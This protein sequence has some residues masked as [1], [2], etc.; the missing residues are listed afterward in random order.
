MF[1][2]LN[3][4]VE[5]KKVLAPH[6][7]LLIDAALKISANTQFSL[8]LREITMLFLEQIADNYSRYLIRKNAVNV[9]DKIIETGFVIA[10]ESEADY[11]GEQETPHSLAL[12]MI[13][14]FASEVPNQIVYPIV[15]KYVDRFGTSA[16]DLE[17]K[18]AIKILGYISDSTCLDMIKE[19]I[20]KITVFIVGKLQDASFVVREATA[21]TV[22]K[23]SEH[24]V[25]DFL[26][27][28]QEVMPSLLKVL[29]ELTIQNDLTIQKSLFALHEFTNNLQDDV[30]QYLP[31]VVPLLLSYI[32]NMQYSRDVRYW[33]LTAMGSVVSS[34]QKRIVPYLEQVLKA[35]YDTIINEQSGSSEQ[36]VRG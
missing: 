11:E 1:E 8:N 25:P 33:A 6:L 35:L 3:E 18:A 19:D 31:V 22:G 15:M 13:Y 34:A 4:F 30:K 2:T 36:L 14:N 7:P 27:M 16:K 20:D 5:I 17:R 23:F 26:D 28:H 9:I 10:S 24:V 12:Y 21:E 32:Q 29:Q